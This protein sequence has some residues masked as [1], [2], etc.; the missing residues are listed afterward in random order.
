M[1]DP[2]RLERLRSDFFSLVAKAFLSLVPLTLGSYLIPSLQAAESNR[3]RFSGV[4][5]SFGMV[6]TSALSTKQVDQSYL[7]SENIA[8][9][10]SLALHFG[11][12][13]WL[14]P[15]NIEL[16][17]GLDWI[18]RSIENLTV[19]GAPSEN[20]SLPIAEALYLFDTFQV[21]LLVGFHV[22]N[23]LMVA[24]GIGIELV[25]FGLTE[26]LTLSD[27]TQT[28]STRKLRDV[29]WNWFNIFLQGG[30]RFS[31]PLTMS[32]NIYLGVQYRIGL[33]D[34]MTNPAYRA[35]YLDVDAM[36]GARFNL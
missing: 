33:I 6:N 34:Q 30:G 14:S 35:R 32:L 4:D 11:T 7:L 24:A 36:F 27:G 1:T 22:L 3:V 10:S 5:F 18:P 25:P 8:S 29:E 28:R 15:N 13:V 21:P 20:P 19:K 17:F 26:Q 2:F 9:R 12:G 16:I 23:D 31:I